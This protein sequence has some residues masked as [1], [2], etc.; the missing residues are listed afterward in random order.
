MRA[1]P[2]HPGNE[3][4][5]CDPRITRVGGWLR[6]TGLDELPQLLNVLRGEMSVVGPRPLLQWEIDRCQPRQRHRLLTEPGLTGLSQVNGRNRIDWDQ[7]IEWDLAYLRSASLRSDLTILC[8]TVRIVATAADAY[9]PTADKA[10]AP[11]I[12]PP[13]EAPAMSPSHAP[14]S[15]LLTMPGHAPG[16][17]IKPLEAEL[18]TQRA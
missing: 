7:R 16:T 8:R 18:A 9:A 1:G 12:P 10:M 11:T 13:H 17:R 6:A 15:A 2:D 3:T 14:H 5:P 4:Q